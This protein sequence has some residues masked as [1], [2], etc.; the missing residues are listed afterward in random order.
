MLPTLT[1]GPDRTQGGSFFFWFLVRPCTTSWL[2]SPGGWGGILTCGL[3][4]RPLLVL[5]RSPRPMRLGFGLKCRPKMTEGGDDLPWAC[6]RSKAI[7][8]HRLTSQQPRRRDGTSLALVRC[9]S[10]AGRRGVF[11]FPWRKKCR[12]PDVVVPSG[13][14]QSEP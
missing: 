10:P 7:L 13:R 1:G 6:H 12:V 9:L 2:P 3:L 11:P 4:R 14:V 8:W 5:E